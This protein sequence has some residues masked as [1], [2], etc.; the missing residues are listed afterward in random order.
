MIKEAFKKA[1]IALNDLRGFGSFYN[2]DLD[3]NSEVHVDAFD[4]HIWYF[5]E[6]GTFSEG[7]DWWFAHLYWWAFRLTF[8]AQKYEQRIYQMWGQLQV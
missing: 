5:T 8:N 3:D 7:F 1:I 6:D 2:L 4:G